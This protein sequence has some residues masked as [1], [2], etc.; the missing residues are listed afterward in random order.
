[1][2]FYLSI[3]ILLFLQSC[4][5]PIGAVEEPIDLIPRDTMGMV[6]NDLIL[7]E[8]HVQN[9][10]LHV[11]K[12]YKIMTLSGDKILSKY[13]LTRKRLEVSMDYYGIHQGDMQSIYTEILDSLNGKVSKI[14]NGGSIKD[15]S[16]LLQ[17]HENNVITTIER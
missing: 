4:M 11:S 8:S 10:Y 16:S 13:H 14:N 12:F 2:R 7:I 6:L 5:N 1:M 17:N 9:K 3:F 15:S